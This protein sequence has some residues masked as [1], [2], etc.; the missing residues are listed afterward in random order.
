MQGRLRLTA[1]LTALVW[2][3]PA[4]A[5]GDSA[6]L[7]GRRL[8]DALRILQARCAPVHRRPAHRVLA[9]LLNGKG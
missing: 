9:G 2:S 1:I 3:M 8:E 5:L 4:I 6:T 7:A